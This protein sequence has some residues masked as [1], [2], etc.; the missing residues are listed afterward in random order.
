MTVARQTLTY[1][2]FFPNFVHFIN[3]GFPAAS[4]KLA[5]MEANFLTQFTL[6]QQWKLNQKGPYFLHLCAQVLLMVMRQYAAYC[7]K[8]WCCII[9]Y[10]VVTYSVQDSMRFSKELSHM[11]WSHKNPLNTTQWYLKSENPN[12]CH[13]M[14]QSDDKSKGTVKPLI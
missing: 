13:R 5:F 4:I 12:H 10:H 14:S 2:I 8:K 11:P 7:K 1:T 6:V 9:C 3:H